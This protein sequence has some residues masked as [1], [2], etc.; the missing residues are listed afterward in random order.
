MYK[1]VQNKFSIISDTG[2]C[3]FHGTGLWSLITT[4]VVLDM[5]PMVS[6]P[7]ES[8]ANNL[9]RIFTLSS[10]HCAEISLLVWIL[11]LNYYSSQ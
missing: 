7:L 11:L 9:F 10:E 2:V 4:Q 6:H 5:M 8:F 3:K 1:K